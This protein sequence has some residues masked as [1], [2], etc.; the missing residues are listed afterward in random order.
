MADFSYS[1]H[2]FEKNKHVR[3]SLREVQISH[4]HAREVALAVRGM[5]LSKAR[6]FLENVVKLKQPVAYRR[7]KNQVGINQIYKAFL[8]EDFQLKLRRNFYDY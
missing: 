5:Y 7:Y 3:A 1:F 4:K 2:N 6:E 8:R